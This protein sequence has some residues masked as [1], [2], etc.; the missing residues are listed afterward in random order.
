MIG[1][2]ECH[3]GLLCSAEDQAE[4]AQRCRRL[5]TGGSPEHLLQ[6]QNRELS[7]WLSCQPDARVRAREACAAILAAKEQA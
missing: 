6:D 7:R 1:S 4:C 2:Y 5:P 3:D